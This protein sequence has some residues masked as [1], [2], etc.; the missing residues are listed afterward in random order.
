MMVSH[1][2]YNTAIDEMSY[3][4]RHFEIVLQ[5]EQKKIFKYS[6]TVVVVLLEN[7]EMIH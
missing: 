1:K 3:E 2:L 7:K 6:K 5:H 4:N